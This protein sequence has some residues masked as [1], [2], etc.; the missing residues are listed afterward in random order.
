[1][2]AASSVLRPR[3]A[4]DQSRSPSFIKYSRNREQIEPIGEDYAEDLASLSSDCTKLVADKVF[5]ANMKSAD[6]SASKKP[7]KSR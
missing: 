5:T 7:L 6:S 2:A 4:K 3:W 1:V